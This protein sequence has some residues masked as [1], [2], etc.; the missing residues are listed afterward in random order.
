ME[1]GRFQHKR[2]IKSM[3]SGHYINTS[4]CSTSESEISNWKRMETTL[5]ADASSSNSSLYLTTTKKG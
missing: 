3:F 4:I 2:P 1:R 5:V